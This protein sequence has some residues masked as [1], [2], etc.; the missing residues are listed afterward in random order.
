M[1]FIHDLVDRTDPQGRTY[2]QVNAE[3]QHQ[4]PIGALVEIVSPDT[5]YPNDSEGVRLFVVK[6]SRDCDQ[7][8]LYCLCHDPDDTIVEQEGFGN[9]K[10]VMGYSE[11]SLKVIRLPE[12][13]RSDG[14]HPG[15][16]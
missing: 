11:E 5:E 12:P 10:W 13:M 14:I 7:T 4:I 16:R 9:R 2:R 3:K 15:L 1:M 8:P 6:H